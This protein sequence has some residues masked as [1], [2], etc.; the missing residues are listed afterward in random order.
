MNLARSIIDAVSSYWAE[1]V[2]ILGS[3]E[4]A[5]AVVCVVYRRTIDPDV[6]LGCRL[7]FHENPADGTGTVEGFAR[8]AAVNLAEPIGIQASRTRQDQY[9]IVWVAI[10]SDRSTPE[11]PA[12]VIRLLAAS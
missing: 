4:D 10:P 12:S 8:D 5:P 7:Q 2:Q 1:E 3:W 11:P 9:G 6:T